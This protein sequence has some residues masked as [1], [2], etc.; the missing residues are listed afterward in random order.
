VIPV[1]G[2]HQWQGSDPAAL[3]T[4]LLN[5]GWTVF[6]LSGL[7]EDTP[8]FFRAIREN[9]P[10]NPPVQSENWDALSDSLWEGLHVFDADKVAVIWPRSDGMRDHDP[11]GFHTAVEVL[12]DIATSLAD[13]QASSARTKPLLVVL[14]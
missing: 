13:P 6:R 7:I 2:V 1:Y 8:S 3:A 11:A 5:A 9:L 14:T 12:M 4:E 10:L